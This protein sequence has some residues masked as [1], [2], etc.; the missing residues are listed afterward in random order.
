[1]IL[2]LS[3]A[4]Y[5]RSMWISE[6]ILT[7]LYADN[8]GKLADWGGDPRHYGLPEPIIGK[9][10]T[11]QVSFLE[12]LLPV[13][14]IE[15]LEFV[16]VGTGRIAHV[17]I[18]PFRG[19]VWVMLLDA[20]VEHDRQQQ[21]QQIANELSLLTYRQS[22]LVH[23]L[24]TACRTLTEGKQRFKESNELKNRLVVALSREIHEQ[25]DSNAEKLLDEAKQADVREARYLSAINSNINQLLTL[26]DNVFDRSKLE[27]G[28]MTVQ[29]AS[30]NPREILDSLEE[31]LFSAARKKNLKIEVLVRS[32]L[33][34]RVSVDELRL[35][36][37]F[38]NLITN[39]IQFTQRGFV[40]LTVGWEAGCL[41]FSVTDSGPGIP[42]ETRDNIF[43]AFQ[44]TN[45]PCM[46]LGLAISHQLVT[47][48]GGELTV[49]STLNEGSAI[50]GFVQAP[51]VRLEQ[52][53]DAAKTMGNK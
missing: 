26:I 21:T 10:I 15:V 33:P 51:L 22:Q 6:K 42:P 41:E 44:Q 48:M 32:I 12:G 31:S 45:I 46:G 23:E 53:N 18:L 24:E 19:G 13:S 38:I 2:P 25:S 14:R 27:T 1:M 47:L 52:E 3:I 9:L 30:C 43:T 34:L 16:C 36:Q 5:I 49:S 4:K 20:S 29:P 37:V 17:H 39:A 8:E 28:K 35:R 7:Y 11:E 40:R 50:N